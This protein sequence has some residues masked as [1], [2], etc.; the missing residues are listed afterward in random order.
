MIMAEETNNN[1]LDELANEIGEQGLQEDS[2]VE[3][4]AKGA[5][6]ALV[7]L[8]E[9]AKGKG[10]K[11]TKAANND[12]ENKPTGDTGTD[13]DDSEGEDNSD[14]DAEQ[15]DGGGS[16][17]ED[18][19]LGDDDEFLDATEFLSGLNGRVEKMSSMLKARDE[20]IVSLESK[21]DTVISE[22]RAFM[23]NLSVVLGPMSKG[24]TE[25]QGRLLDIEA[26]AVG[27]GRITPAMRARHSIKDSGA[28]TVAKTTLL[29]GV[30]QGIFTDH[31]HRT[32][33][34]TG[35]FVLD[36][37]AADDA[38]REKLNGLK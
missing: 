14:E 8:S 33:K 32:Y 30:Q 35:M 11:T 36:D 5:A 20:K 7:N 28:P 29:K 1:A 16:S 10:A 34:Q 9:M 17:F 31:Q 24:V 19:N 13:G 2:V 23:D 25:L 27:D 15:G 18:M 38:I 6:A 3:T 4:L 12:A 21:I 22:Q 26:P 37:K